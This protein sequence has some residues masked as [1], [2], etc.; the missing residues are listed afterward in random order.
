M[1]NYSF[2]PLKNLIEQ[3][4]RLLGMTTFECTTSVFNIS[5]QNNSFSIT[6]PGHLNSKSAEKTIVELNKLLE[7]R[8]QNDIDLYVTEVKKRGKLILKRR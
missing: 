3:G 6:I 5:D 7:L 2:S 4:K 1:Q 8:S